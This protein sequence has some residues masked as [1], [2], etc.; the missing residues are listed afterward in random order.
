LF[1]RPRDGLEFAVAAEKAGQLNREMVGGRIERPGR[2]AVG[3]VGRQQLKQPLGFPQAGEPVL[4]EVSQRSIRGQAV[5]DQPGGDLREQH[6]VAARRRH[7]AGCTVHRRSV[8]VTRAFLAGT[9]V[10]THAHP[11]R[12]WERPG[13]SC[14]GA[15]SVERGPQGVGRPGE[16]GVQPVAGHLDDPAAAVK[17]GVTQDR[18][19]PR[20]RRVHRPRVLLPE[21]RLSMP[22][23]S[24]RPLTTRDAS[25]LPC[26]F[27]STPTSCIGASIL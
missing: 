21:G 23:H 12:P 18:I 3:Q 19:G 15:L 5:A 16:D 6:L 2:K 22:T 26:H 10:Q 14:H 11:K 4:A 8:V 17:H 20:Q 25:R 24:W 1:E 27:S 9:T 13:L 7:D